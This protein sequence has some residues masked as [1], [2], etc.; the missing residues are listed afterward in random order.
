MMEVLIDFNWLF[1][2]N[3]PSCRDDHD[4]VGL[5]SYPRHHV[6]QVETSYRNANS[7]VDYDVDQ[8]NNF[9]ASGR[10]ADLGEYHAGR[11][12]LANL[13]ESLGNHVGNQ[14]EHGVRD[15][16]GRDLGA[17]GFRAQLDHEVRAL[18]FGAELVHEIRSVG[19]ADFR[20]QLG[21]EVRAQGVGDELGHEVRSVGAEHQ[22]DLRARGSVEK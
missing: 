18:G 8:G 5:D 2:R 12:C 11:I 3:C 9:V 16:V 10:E 4:K 15:H 22:V 20:A 13:D 17:V 14:V 1:I 19:A 21:H 7:A 6:A